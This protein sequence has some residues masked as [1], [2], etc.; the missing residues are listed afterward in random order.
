MGPDPR[1]NHQ[2]PG[3][4]MGTRVISLMR[5]VGVEDLKAE[6]LAGVP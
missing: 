6:S 3:P 5:A 4:G 1:Q 2:S